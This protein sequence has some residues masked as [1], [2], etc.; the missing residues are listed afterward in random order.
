MKSNIEQVGANLIKVKYIDYEYS[1]EGFDFVRIDKIIGIS[2]IGSRK[3]SKGESYFWFSFNMGDGN[4]NVVASK[5]EEELAADLEK[6]ITII[7]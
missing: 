5:N 7:G 1:R 2:T 6:L 3:T 4:S